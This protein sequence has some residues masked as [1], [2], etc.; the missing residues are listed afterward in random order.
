MIGYEP[1]KQADCKPNEVDV[2]NVIGLTVEGAQAQLAAMPLR[3]EIISRPARAGEKLGMVVDQ[4]PKV[5]RTL[6]SW[7]TVRIVTAESPQGPIPR[8]VGLRVSR[9]EEI[10]SAMGL[11]S[12]IECGRRQGRPGSS[13]PSSPA[14]GGRPSRG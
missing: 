7:D 8:L 4:Y 2:P 3:A 13:S 5:G 11:K 9:A 10:L 14:P 6:S 1:D 12:A